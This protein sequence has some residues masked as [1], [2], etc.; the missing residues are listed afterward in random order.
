MTSSS[1]GLAAFAFTLLAACTH[2]GPQMSASQYLHELCAGPA[3]RPCPAGERCMEVRLVSA[4]VLSTNQLRIASTYR[5]NDDN[6]PLFF[7]QDFPEAHQALLA[8]IRIQ[9]DV[10]LSEIAA[11]AQTDELGNDWLTIDCDFDVHC[12]RLTPT[13]ADETALRSARFP[14]TNAQAAATY[15]LS[16]RINHERNG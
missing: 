14:C 11:S 12:I 15:L 5:N 3:V 8:P 13:I 7:R 2:P 9:K 4:E 10:Q 1:R 16:L 6:T